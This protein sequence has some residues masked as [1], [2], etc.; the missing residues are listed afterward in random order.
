MS[1][2]GRAMGR[3]RR[4]FFH[5]RCGDDVIRDENGDEL[6][7][8]RRALERAVATAK[9]L[10]QGSP[11]QT[12]AWSGCVFEVTGPEGEAVWRVPVSDA[13]DRAEGQ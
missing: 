7:D 9:A 2:E 3:A 12:A 1:A 6:A 11:D 4:Y 8:D 13:L 5:L 10:L